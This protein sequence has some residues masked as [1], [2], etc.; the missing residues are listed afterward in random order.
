[1]FKKY[2]KCIFCNSKNLKS[3]NFPNSEINFYIKAIISDL[4]KKINDLNKIKTYKCQNCYIIQNNP[5]FTEE[6]SRKIYTRIYGQ[7]NRNWS[8][9]LNF[10]N[11]GTKADHGDL[12]KIL[13]K[14][15][16]I[17]SYTEF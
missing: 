15:I 16:N 10:V 4:D 12:Y 5:W 13:R 3:E 8:N 2:N 6:N 17:K 7:H 14:K 9:I 1:M 11:Y